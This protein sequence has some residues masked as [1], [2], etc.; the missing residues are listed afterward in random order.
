[1]SIRYKEFGAEELERIKDIYR[2]EGWT[3]Y[4]QDDEALCRAYENSLYCLGV[5]DEDTM[6]GFVRCVGDGEHILLVQDLIIIPEY[7]RKGIGTAL[8]KQVWDKY[9]HV[10]M[11]QVN[12]DMA[13]E[14]DN[15][16]YQA[17]GMKPISDGGMISYFR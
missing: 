2:G 6:I 5:Y 9:S 17:M 11:F 1:M 10:R 8:L 12:T 7:Q 15:H 16:F 13:D 3:A 14:R 4:L